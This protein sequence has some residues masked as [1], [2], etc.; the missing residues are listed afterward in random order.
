MNAP[1]PATAAEVR[2]TGRQRYVR[3]FPERASFLLTHL[4]PAQLAAY[5]RILAA[6]VVADGALH[7]DAT[8]RALSGLSVKAWQELRALLELLGVARIEG[9]QWVDADQDVNLKIQRQ[10][11]ERQRARAVIRWR[12]KSA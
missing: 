10:I 1:I 9:E 2:R 12:S 3:L 8:L 4:S 11:T 5:L 6:Y 7:G